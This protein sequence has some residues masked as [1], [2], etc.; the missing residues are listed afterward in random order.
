M[1]RIE[2][3]GLPSR[4][5]DMCVRVSTP[6][7]RLGARGNVRPEVPGCVGPPWQALDWVAWPH[8]RQHWSGLGPPR[9]KEGISAMVRG[10]ARPQPKLT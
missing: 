6:A 1:L 3:P 10:P 7:D 2:G 4:P 5:S 9:E 8:L